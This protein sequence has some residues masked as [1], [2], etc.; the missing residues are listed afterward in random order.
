MAF[1]LQ[2]ADCK[3]TLKGKK[4]PI[5]NMLIALM[6]ISIFPR[7]KTITGKELRILE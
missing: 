6:M 1:E 7:Q 2:L 5:Q 4:I 3:M